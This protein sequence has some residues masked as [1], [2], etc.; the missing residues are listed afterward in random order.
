MLLDPD[1]VDRV[2]SKEDPVPAWQ[3][4]LTRRVGGVYGVA[5]ERYA[6]ALEPWM[7][8]LCQREAVANADAHLRLCR[9]SGGQIAT[10]A[11]SGGKD[12]E[13]L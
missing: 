7:A 5:A 3:R 10:D 11:T 2:A 4:S 8:A 12:D 9:A 13:R 6:V 1:A